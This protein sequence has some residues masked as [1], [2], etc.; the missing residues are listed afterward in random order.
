MNRRTFLQAVSLAVTA[1]MVPAVAQAAVEAKAS[2]H[3]LMAYWR[4]A[5]DVV[6]RYPGVAFAT[7]D[8]FGTGLVRCSDRYEWQL[9][10][11]WIGKGTRRSGVVCITQKQVYENTKSLAN[12]RLEVEGLC[13]V[14][15][16]WHEA[17]PEFRSVY[18]R[19]FDT[20]WF[21]V[22]RPYAFT[23]GDFGTAVSINFVTGEIKY[24]VGH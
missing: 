11:T 14:L 7:L 16:E 18:V 24:R 15:T 6:D 4:E 19:P 22:G 1:A 13:E 3:P 12:W 9:R 23:N 20:A 5:A 10:L 17:P 21:E 8:E 2:E